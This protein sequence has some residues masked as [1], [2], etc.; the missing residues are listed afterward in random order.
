MNSVTFGNSK[1]KYRVKKTPRRKTSQIMVDRVGVQVISPSKKSVKQ[2]E[3][4]VRTHSKWIYK[5]QLLVKREKRVEITFENGSRLPYLG[6]NYLLEIKK[7]KSESFRFNNGKFLIRLNKISKS[8]IRKLYQEWSKKNAFPVLEK[9]VKKYS[10]KIGIKTGKIILKNHK[11]RW[12]SV[13]KNGTLN[14]NK[15][16]L[17]APP[18]I[19]DYVTAHEL[20]H[21]KIPNHSAAYWRLLEK[22]LPDYEDKKE[23]LKV[24]RTLLMD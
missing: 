17:R 5:K 16:L 20:C 14:F 7:S 24:N 15:N 6:K 11:N 18:K 3:N 19:I 8:K 4:L 23:W 12:G 1:I 10:R 21:L 22:V 13:S 2:I 9:S